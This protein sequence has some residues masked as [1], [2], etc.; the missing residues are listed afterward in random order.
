MLYTFCH[1]LDILLWCVIACSVGYVVFFATASLFGGCRRRSNAAKDTGALTPFVILFPAYHE[2]N[3]IVGS[4][5][6]FLNQQYPSELFR[7]VVISD[8]MSDDTNERLRQLPVMLLTPQF[9]KSSKAKAM[10]YAMAELQRQGIPTAVQSKTTEQLRVVVLDADN[11]VE[12]D[13]LLRLNSICKQGWQAIQCHRCA[14]NSDNS[15]AVLD[16]VSEEINNTIFR[17]AHNAI[18]LSSALIGSG[19]CFVYN[20]FAEHVILLKSAVEDRELE[21]ILMRERIFVKF[22]PD[23]HVRDEKVNSSDNF[24]R[25]R[26]RWIT[27]QVQTLFLMLPCV[28]KAVLTFNIDYLDK[29]LQ[30][31]LIPRSILLAV[32][33]LISLIVLFV[34]PVHSVK[35]WILA[36]LLM[37]SLWLAIPSQLRTRAVL[38]R[39]VAMPKLV[40]SMMRNILHIDRKNT[41]FL[42]TTHG[43]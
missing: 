43:K 15:I 36:L 22:E 38:H 30:Q 34:S 25:Q 8:H 16:G 20:W 9:E 23:I 2:D 13:F 12:P 37:V 18:G 17:K 35:W 1:V 14:K 39:A 40:V 27:G 31:T 21:A 33:P 24:Q 26:Q 5:E 3:V 10:Q 11:V 41:D 4:V 28:P 42:H 32:V 19:M 29:T 7:V 6:T